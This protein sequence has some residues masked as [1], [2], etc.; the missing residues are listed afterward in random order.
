M[1]NPVPFLDL[2]TTQAEIQ[3]ELEAAYHRVLNSNWFILGHEVT[4]FEQ[5]FA[6]YCETKYCVGVGNG[7]DA[8]R[9]IL[10][11][12]EIGVGDEVIVPTFTFI[13]T[14]LAVSAVGAT[15]VLV[16]P[17]EQTY[18]LDPN[19]IE[20]AITPKT[21]AIIPVHLYGQPADMTP[22][23]ALAQKYQLKVIED[24]AQAHGACY[25]SRKVGSLGDAAAFSFYPVKNLGALGDGGAVVTDDEE[26]VKKIRQLGNYGSTLKYQ[27]DIKGVNSRLD[28]LQAA[29]LQVKLA[30]LP[31]WNQHRQAIATFYLENLAP[32][33]LILPVTPAYANS[34]WHLFVIRSKQRDTLQKYLASAGI[35]TMIH[36]PIPLHLQPAYSELKLPLKTFPI[37][38]TLAREV[39]S[40]PMGPNLTL[41]QAQRV[42]N[43]IHDYVLR[44]SNG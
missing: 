3:T 20:T 31:T 29:F 16:E 13:A 24:A 23:L 21:R 40:L 34:V 9:L 1:T 11:G 36:Y 8:L 18:N 5:Q 35:G 25:K 22:I 17:D 28:E 38:E 30:K 42:V 6:N 32:L 10:M 7:L 44:N 14:W 19:R 15:P 43:A 27:H 37:A 39:L 26:L 2:A 33:P 4:Q 41:K 12:Y